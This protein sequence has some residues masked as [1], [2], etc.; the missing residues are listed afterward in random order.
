MSAVRNEKR[1]KSPKRSTPRNPYKLFGVNTIWAWPG[2]LLWY[3]V[4]DWWVRCWR[5]YEILYGVALYVGE[6]G[7]GK[8]M[9]MVERALRLKSRDPRIIVWSNFHFEG[10]DY[11]FRDLAEL[12][13]IP[14]YSVLLISEGALFANA[15][16]WTNFP[17]GLVEMLTQNRK[18][19]QGEGRPPGVLMLWDVQDPMMIDTNVRRLTNSVI[20]CKAYCDFGNFPRL[21]VQWFSSPR[22]YFNSDDPDK[23]RKNGFFC[24]IATDELRRRYNTYQ[25]LRGE[26]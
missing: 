25:Q 6:V 18:W 12:E 17:A 7:S 15:R 16:D 8:T 14:S 13:N 23:V 3:L 22:K 24:Y 1:G 21:M 20:H 9:G 10:C 2:L 5:D 26:G 4:K 19:G 11:V